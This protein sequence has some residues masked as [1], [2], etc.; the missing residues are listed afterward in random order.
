MYDLIAQCAEL[1]EH[2]HHVVKVE[3]FRF[4]IE[5]A[6][7]KP[8]T[9]PRPEGFGPNDFLDWKEHKEYYAQ[10][11]QGTVWTLE[12]IDLAE[13]T[14]QALETARLYAEVS[15]ATWDKFNEISKQHFS[16]PGLAPCPLCKCSCI[17]MPSKQIDSSDSSTVVCLK[18]PSH[19]I[20]WQPWGG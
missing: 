7:S 20:D 11:H 6:L 19:V 3:E 5:R 10:L 14:P 13:G 2:W 4:E 16:L 1:K 15:K 12:N 17:A 9:P 8:Q 18:D